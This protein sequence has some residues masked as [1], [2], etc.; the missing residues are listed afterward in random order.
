MPKKSADWRD[1]RKKPPAPPLTR[2][3]RIDEW[4]DICFGQYGDGDPWDCHEHFVGTDDEIVDLFTYTML[5]SGSELL[6]FSDSQLGHGLSPLT[7]SG[8]SDVVRSVRDGQHSLERKLGALRS[9]K[10]LYQHCLTPRAPQVLGHL[11]EP[12]DC[13]PLAYFCYMFWDA[14]PLDYWPDSTIGPM[15]YPVVA[16]VMETALHSPNC[17]VIESG[18]HGLGHMVYKYAG[19]TQIIDQFISQRQSTVRPELMAYARAARTGGIL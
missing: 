2:P 7:D 4:L 17:A 5:H 12:A 3:P 14:S 16:E 1:P 18:L 15:V 6:R 10:C 8:R 9:I 19:A 13:K 11:S